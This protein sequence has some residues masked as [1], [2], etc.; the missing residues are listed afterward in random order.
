M[1]SEKLYKLSQV[2]T[3]ASVSVRTVQ[4]HVS[5]GKINVKRIGPYRLPRVSETELRRYLGDHEKE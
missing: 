5:D 3:A 1:T 4:K 2:A